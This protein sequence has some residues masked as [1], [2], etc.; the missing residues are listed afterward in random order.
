MLSVLAWC[1][2]FMEKKIK[3]I[4]NVPFL[5]LF[6]CDMPRPLLPCD[7]LVGEKTLQETSWAVTTRLAFRFQ[8]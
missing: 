3:S 1:Y 6:C 7:Q 8:F 4:K 2:V 5:L